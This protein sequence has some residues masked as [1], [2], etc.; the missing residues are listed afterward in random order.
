MTDT[1]FQQIDVEECQMPHASPEIRMYGTT[2]EGHPVL[3]HVHGFFPYFFVHA[4]RGFTHSAC[5]DFKNALNTTFG[6]S[7]IADVKLVSKKNL[8]QYT[9]PENIAFIRITV[10]DLRL[11]GRVRGSFERGEIAFRDLFVPGEPLVS[12]DHVAYT[13]RFMIDYDIVGMNWISIRSG[14]YTVRE[15][16]ACIARCQIELDCRPDAIV[17][18]PSQGE[19]L[20]MAPL[21]ILSF[22][23][24]CA[25]RKGVFPDPSIDPVI[26]I[27][28]M[29]TRQ[30]ESTPFVKNIFTLGSCSHIVGCHVMSFDNEVE[31]LEAWANFVQHVDPDVIIGYNTS[32]FDL[33]Y[34]LERAKT[35]R[36]TAF[37]F[38]GREKNARTES[39]DTHFSSK[40]YGTRD[41]K[42]TELQGRLQLDMLQVMQR[43]YKLRSYSLNSVSF[44]FL[45][46]QKEDVHHS[47]ITELQNSGPEARRRL[48]VY[49]LKDAYLPQ[50]LMDKLMCLINYTEMARVTGVP[51]NYLLSRGQQIKVISQLFR[52][53]RVDG[54]LIPAYKGDGKC[55]K[56]RHLHRWR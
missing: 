40:A 7:S 28:N 51:F 27:A 4:P 37:P 45:G 38:L 22:D 11:F 8:M 43:D 36:A 19:W 39:K 54:Y 5:N 15:P 46:E 55:T 44:E 32:N 31:M 18:H 9:G 56:S 33:P 34:L 47:L 53:A 50:R 35:V 42:H 3:V 6:G 14:H 16:N 41:S 1:V 23:I 13:L 17:S 2:L 21:R 30:G 29:V 12:F 25:G 10:A 48:A 20:K 26:Q 49:C 24:E 52:K